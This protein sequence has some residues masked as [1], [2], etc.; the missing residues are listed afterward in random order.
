MVE[1][2]TTQAVS[3]NRD[4]SASTSTEQFPRM[5]QSPLQLQ[6]NNR[7]TYVSAVKTTLQTPTPTKKQAIVLHAVEQL[8]LF[9][10]VKALS[11]IVTPKNIIF[12]S[13]I[14]NQRICIYLSSTEI[15]DDLM[16]THDKITIGDIEIPIRRLIN[17]ARRIVISNVCPDI[18]NEI[19]ENVLKNTGIKLASPVSHLRA[20]FQG[21]DFAHILSFRRQVY[22]SSSQDNSTE[23]PAT[24]LISYEDTNYRIFLSTDN[25]ECF[26]CK[27]QGHI[28]SNC[29]NNQEILP[30]TL[31]TQEMPKKRAASTTSPTPSDNLIGFNSPIEQVESAN[32]HSQDF[33]FIT[34]SPQTGSKM[35]TETKQAKKKI[36]VANTT[37]PT[38]KVT[39]YN[40]LKEIF[41]NNPLDYTITYDSFQ[42]FLEGCQGNNK[43]LAEARRYT[44]NIRS[45][46]ETIKSLYNR[47]NDRNLRNRF[48]RLT[49][50]IKKQL[51]EE[52]DDTES[53]ASLQ[54]QTSQTEIDTDHMEI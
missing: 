54:S 4:S 41:E 48:T 13:K 6:S 33:Q 28:A 53:I 9:D 44:N 1:T 19:L 45:L 36:K 32:T 14:S 43:P 35:K 25:M 7:P 22:I 24:M 2:T 29:P 40:T 38:E 12:A 49:R 17:P 31:N 30:S 46:L 11:E 47:L 42:C 50:S 27:E 8:K 52:G 51:K 20:G 23:L 3:D 21:N 15:V 10:Y 5:S 34:P 18:P 26:V 16:N 39:K 37:T